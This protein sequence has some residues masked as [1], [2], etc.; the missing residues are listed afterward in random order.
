MF[1]EWL[2]SFITPGESIKI[3]R[4]EKQS[5][6]ISIS[7]AVVSYYAPHV[8]ADKII[9]FKTASGAKFELSN[10]HLLKK[11]TRAYRKKNAGEIISFSANLTVE[12]YNYNGSTYVGKIVK[13]KKYKS[14]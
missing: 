8:S 5:K 2:I 6:V 3:D 10:A 1:I 11:V 7:N 4:P 13:V 12:D 9:N 14:T